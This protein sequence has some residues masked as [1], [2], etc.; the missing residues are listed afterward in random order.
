MWQSVRSALWAAR[1]RGERAI[2]FASIALAGVAM[3][4]PTWPWFAIASVLLLLLSIL[5][6]VPA[7]RRRVFP[8]HPVRAWS[9]LVVLAWGFVLHGYY[10]EL[11][12][13]RSERLDILG[14]E[15]PRRRSATLSIGVD[16]SVDVRLQRADDPTLRW[17]LGVRE[18][19]DG[20]FAVE[21]MRGVDA[22]QQQERME[23]TARRAIVRAGIRP[24]RWTHLTG[25]AL[26]AESRTATVTATPAAQL[27]PT[28]IRDHRFELR[29][30]S[31]GRAEL[32]WNGVVL[33]LRLPEHGD[34]AV[35]VRNTRLQRQL[36][37]GV[38]L[39]ALPWPSF[40]D[41]TLARDLVLTL[42]SAPRASLAIADPLHLLPRWE[43]R[44]TARDGTW[45]VQQQAARDEK[46]NARGLPILD[47]GDSVRIS[48]RGTQWVFVL[49]ARD[50]GAY[51]ARDV[52][53]GFGRRPDP[54]LGWLP[55][56]EV[57]RPLERCTLV[58][59]RALAPSIPHFDLSGFGLDTATFEFLARVAVDGNSYKVITPGEV[60]TVPL[61][62]P[63]LIP[64]QATDWR[65]NASYRLRVHKIASG[66]LLAVALTMVALAL[67]LAGA[68]LLT[69]RSERV[70]RL[71]AQ[72][73]IAVNTA[74]AVA[75]VTVVLLGLRL[76][77]GLRVTYAAPYHERDVSTA[78]GMWVVVTLLTAALLRWE[79]WGPRVVDR[80]LRLEGLVRIGNRTALGPVL[81]STTDT[82]EAQTVSRI[83]RGV[84]LA[85]LHGGVALLGWLR[86]E[87]LVRSG[88]IVAFVLAT[89]V[90]IEYLSARHG[91]GQIAPSAGSI[92]AGGRTDNDPGR[93]LAL[94]V[95]T[96]GIPFSVLVRD[97]ALP[98]TL[99]LL[100]I[101]LV[102]AAVSAI[103]SRR[104]PSRKLGF[105]E[106]AE[107]LVERTS[108]TSDG[109]D[110]SSRP[111]FGGQAADTPSGAFPAYGI[112]PEDDISAPPR[113]GAVTV[114]LLFLVVLNVAMIL[115]GGPTLL[116]VGVFFLFLLS[117]RTGHH[118]VEAFTK[119]LSLRAGAPLAALALA[120]LLVLPIDFGLL[121]VLSVPL[122]VTLL[123]TLG[124]DRIPL[125]SWALLAVLFVAVGLISK[126]V[127]WPDVSKIQIDQRAHETAEEFAA[128]GGPLRSWPVFEDPVRRSV[129]RGLASFHPEILELVLARAAPSPA[130]EELIPA[131]EHIW[132]GRAYAASGLTG[133]GL[134]GP[135]VIGRGV[136]EVVSD[137][138]NTFSVYV[139]AEH[140]LLGGLAVLA[141]YAVLVCVALA[142][143][144]SVWRAPSWRTRPNDTATAVLVGGILMITVPAVYVAASNLALVPLTG[145]N[146][147]FLGLNAWSDVAFV[148]A[149]L[150]AMF[151]VLLDTRLLTNERAD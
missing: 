20:R 121:L 36:R 104:S 137:A 63:V 9:L 71:L 14:V 129:V 15:F 43:L 120:L 67:V 103:Q 73:T 5:V 149:L 142:F 57:C 133:H 111:F 50:H 118:L 12:R 109:R 141:A 122:A 138:E 77:L 38:E 70:A 112:T 46:Q 131:R 66:E 16:D 146:M 144:W 95:V 147:P 58:S 151:A 92:L 48:A 19:P 23:S 33:P 117:V 22:I 94:G 83:P 30:G 44:L 102:G 97:G 79:A 69:A 2:I 4:T 18:L 11:H 59:S 80:L 115:A 56:A 113:W 6:A 126:P 86:P 25:V 27:A 52:A 26:T 93:R 88:I 128:L 3:F 72:D 106:E 42:V 28:A 130:R 32:E 40:P 85:L 41:T 125:R 1:S 29:L 132:G 60:H 17:R 110:D 37:R 124:A 96:V 90:I 13:Q 108:E 105:R 116:F 7:A 65:S 82:H 62:Q 89:W 75:S 134:A 136:P 76:A 143:L 53:V 100:V 51:G 99:G 127:L 35:E 135:T 150:S 24:R 54:R 45:L 74:W 39:A 49:E 81:E 10:V 123:L 87:A 21:E 114:V 55:A 148:G 101:L 91:S 61:G 34:P 140:G 8:G 119:R 31:R 47:A 84:G 98:L 64:A 68:G 145:Q 78:V 139:L 107:V